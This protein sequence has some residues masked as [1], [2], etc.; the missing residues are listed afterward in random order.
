ML[1]Q[2]DLWLPGHVNAVRASLEEAKHAV[3]SVA[4]SRFIDA[5]GRDIGKWSQ[6]F[7]PGIRPGIDF[8]RALIVQNFLAIPSPVIRRDA[9]ISADGLDEDLWYTADWDLY[10]KLAQLGDV[11]VRSAVTTGF[12]IHGNSLTMTGSRTASAF[13]EQH[14][15]VLRRHGDKFGL[16]RDHRLRGRARASAEINCGLASAAAGH[17]GSLLPIMRRLLALGPNDAWYYLRESSIIDRLLPRLRARL[18]GRL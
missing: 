1:H 7:K 5:T 10:L 17:A 12:R 2:D 3:M 16:D 14:E 6:P 15:I 13:R 4:A 18:V 8:G 9:W 11:T